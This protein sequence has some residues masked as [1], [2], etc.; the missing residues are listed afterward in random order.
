MPRSLALPLWALIPGLVLSGCESDTFMPPPNPELAAPVS[1]PPVRIVEMI[2]PS[3][4]TPDQNALAQYLRLVSSREKTSYRTS[5]PEPND[6]PRRQAD[7]I[8]KAAERGASV[9]IVQPAKDAEVSK[10]LDEVRA[11]GVPSVLLADP[12]SEAGKGKPFPI[13]EAA[14][15]SDAAGKLVDAA[16]EAAKTA[17]LPADGTAVILSVAK[18]DADL[19]GCGDALAAALQAA[20]IASPEPLTY[21]GTLEGAKSALTKRLEADLKL[22]IVAVCE[23][24]GMTGV[25]DLRS[26]LKDKRP[27][28]VV[29][30]VANDPPPN[31]MLFSQTAGIAIRNISQLA[32][33]AFKAALRL[34]DGDAV[35]ER[36]TVPDEFRLYPSKYLDIPPEPSEGPPKTD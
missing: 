36:T 27:I 25:L 1:A 14:P 16:V 12:L 21:D 30:Y 9:L 29:G 22:A 15:F 26:K 31:E 4:S 24:V 7:A 34:A 11:Q 20:K 3:E 6:P 35:P 18:P 33:E 19:K 28:V 13:V 2:L 17:K 8:R 5:A 23:Q 32:R 10:A